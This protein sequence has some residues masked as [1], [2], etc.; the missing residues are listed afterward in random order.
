MELVTTALPAP[1]PAGTPIASSPFRVEVTYSA[2]GLQPLILPA[3]LDVVVAAPS[4]ELGGT[5]VTG[6]I[7]YQWETAGSWRLLPSWVDRERSELHVAV[8]GNAT[9]AIAAVTPRTRT[10]EPGWNLVPFV[11][12]P[13][14][15]VAFLFAGLDVAV[16]AI[17]VWDASTQSYRSA[18]PLAPSFSTLST[19]QPLDTLWVHVRSDEPVEWAQYGAA[20]PAITLPLTPGWMLLP[21]VEAETPVTDGAAD[22]F[23]VAPAVFRWNAETGAYDAFY[24]AGP[25]PVNTL[26][27]LQPLDGLWIVV[28]PEAE[29]SWIQP[30]LGPGVP[31][32]L[33]GGDPS[34]H[35]PR[36]ARIQRPAG[37]R[38]PRRRRRRCR[39]WR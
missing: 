3:F 33:R 8:A 23:G 31:S 24:S 7:A 1:L 13:G 29:A 19:V 21:W 35:R 5:P 34:C 11:G 38:R 25:A 27:M 16:D 6:L 2:T 39:R 28:S 17:H 30:G 37:G 20:L 15:P 18:F 12:A 10:L 14:M 36:A 4:A 32:V 9:L 26:T 22:L